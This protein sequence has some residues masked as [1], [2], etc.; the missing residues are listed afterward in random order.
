MTEQL[1]NNDPALN[2]DEYS[3][4]MISLFSRELGQKYPQLFAGFSGKLNVKVGWL[5]LLMEMCKQLDQLMEKYDRRVAI[6]ILHLDVKAGMLKVVGKCWSINPANGH[7]TV[8]AEY[9]LAGLE[10]DHLPALQEMLNIIFAAE[11]NSASTCE[12]CGL[13]ATCKVAKNFENYTS[14]DKHRKSW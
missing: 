7:P 14:C 1:Y 8:H 13:P 2:L 11:D 4:A 10:Q 5:P 6:S 3:A 12:V 9:N